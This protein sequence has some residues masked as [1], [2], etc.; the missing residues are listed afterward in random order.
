MDRIIQSLTKGTE[1]AI[2]QASQAA[3]NEAV[4]RTPVKTGKTIA[5]W[6]VGLGKVDRGTRAAPNTG[7]R[8]TNRNTG[9]A[10]SL[11]DAANRIS[12][13][14]YNQHGNIY[15]SNGV[16][17]AD[18]LDNGSSRQAPAGMSAFAIKAAQA[19]LR[20]VRLLKDG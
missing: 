7:D 3:V 8:E 9:A 1:D 20:K 12:A 19:V 15:I 16:D 11:I 10:E 17:Y 18:D 2:K 4:L 5:S 6:K 13:W 14:K